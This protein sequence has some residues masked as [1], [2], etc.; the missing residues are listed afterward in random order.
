M[1]SN[2]HGKVSIHFVKLSAA[3]A[4]AHARK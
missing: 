2:S 1:Y 4:A 3:A